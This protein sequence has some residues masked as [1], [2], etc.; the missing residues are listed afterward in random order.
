M[1]DDEFLT[2]NFLTGAGEKANQRHL[3]RLLWTLGAAHPKRKW[4]YHLD[5][6]AA[7]A[8]PGRVGQQT[9]SS[10]FTNAPRKVGE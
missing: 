1:L 3:L 6:G 5:M 4:L 10:V 7:Q 8:A 2:M 9:I